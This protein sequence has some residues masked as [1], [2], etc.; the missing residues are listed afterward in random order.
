MNRNIYILFFLFIFGV[1]LT[2]QAQRLTIGTVNACAGQEVL[3]PVTGSG[4]TGIGAITL[5]IS[6]SKKNLNYIGLENIDTQLNG[7][8]FSYSGSLE[9]FTIAW[10]NL[11]SANFAN[12]K[13]FDIR[14]LSNGI[15]TPVEFAAGC[16]ITSTSLII[17]QTALDNGAISAMAPSI[18]SQPVNV[19]VVAGKS[20]SF[21]VQSPDAVS[22]KWQEKSISSGN[23]KDL[24]DAGVYSGA[25][26][27]N[28]I[29][30]AVPEE[31]NRNAYRC[32]L[33]KNSCPAYSTDAVLTIDSLAAVGSKDNTNRL[34]V[35]NQPNPFTDFTDLIIRLNQEGT[36]RI[37]VYDILG[38]L[39]KDYGV[40]TLQQGE[41]RFRIDGSDFSKGIY[42]AEITLI[43]ND[44]Q[45]RIIHKMIRK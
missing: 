40:V 44:N 32:I 21:N 15:S 28:L 6:I 39:I 36:S 8:S 7:A 14:I 34:S 41:Q 31:F 5:N 2:A 33:D 38:S 19:T 25:N 24:N 18:T 30:N 4:L 22:Y 11:T 27:N 29:I 17:V 26:T 35:V 42:L 13:L 23:W 37:K 1:I 9:K 45:S 20:A 12:S 3:L 43:Q 16:E 10:S